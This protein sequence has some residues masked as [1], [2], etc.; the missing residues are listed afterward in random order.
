MKKTSI[1]VILWNSLSICLALKLRSIMIDIDPTRCL[2]NIAEKGVT[3]RSICAKGYICACGN[4]VSKGNCECYLPEHYTNFVN[5]NET[6]N[7][8]C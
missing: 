8:S 1:Y 2:R 4:T 3:R 6:V 7:H 5:K